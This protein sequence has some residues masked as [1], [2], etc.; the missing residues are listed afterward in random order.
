MSHRETLSLAHTAQCKLRLA[1]D[2]PDRNLRFLLGHALTLDSLNLRLMQIEDESQTV[3][4]PKHSSSVK[5]KAA[6]SGVKKHSPLAGRQ[7]T[8][9]PSEKNN[10]EDDG[11][12]SESDHDGLSLQRFPSAA[13]QPPRHLATERA[14]PQLDPHD[15]VSSSDD[16]ELESFLAMLEQNLSKESLEKITKNPTDESLASLYH[17]IQNCPCHKS[18]APEVK[19]FWELPDDQQMGSI[20]G[21][22]NIRIAIAEVGA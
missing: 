15:E 13:A 16:E 20:K 22:D 19:N 9:P 18:D 4:Q 21:F 14:P 7:K 5:F 6:D 11:N 8:P 12:S 3:R 2:K 10:E 17:S 1:A